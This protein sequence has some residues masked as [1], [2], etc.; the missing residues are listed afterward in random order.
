MDD[1]TQEEA[2]TIAEWLELEYECVN[3]G[4]EPFACWLNAHCEPITFGDEIV[5]QDQIDSW[6]LSPEGQSAIIDKLGELP[7]LQQIV[8]FR[9]KENEVITEKENKV[10]QIILSSPNPVEEAG[11]W[12]LHEGIAPTR[13]LALIKAVLEMLEGGE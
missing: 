12:V 5:L 8:F 4:N 11:Y 10:I 6:L 13:Q 2:V 1:I 9:E 3:D 7:T